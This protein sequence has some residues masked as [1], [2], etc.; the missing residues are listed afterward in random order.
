MQIAVE[1]LLQSIPPEIA[2]NIQLET[3]CDFIDFC[4]T[5]SVNKKIDLAYKNLKRDLINDLLNEVSNIRKVIGKRKLISEI[6]NRP[7][8]S[9]LDCERTLI[10]HELGENN[11]YQFKTNYKKEKLTFLIDN[12]A[13]MNFSRRL[14]IARSLAIILSSFYNLPQ[15]KLMIFSEGVKE[16]DLH[17]IDLKVFLTEYL[18]V[19][20]NGFTDFS[21]AL[22]QFSQHLK[23]N[24]GKGLIIS[25]GVSSV[26]TKLP[27]MTFSR[28][29]VHYIK[30]GNK[31][32]EVDQKL[33]NA[34][35]Q[36][37]GQVLEL[38]SQVSLLKP[39]YQIMK[40]L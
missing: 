34:L 39:L 31:T 38:K 36:S 32:T 24:G 5:N 6:S 18:T 35:Y 26:G 9:V 19:K 21:K 7:D 29:R 8:A 23:L 10:S 15:M 16:V 30:L 37:C 40:R 27:A 11:W 17:K 2:D 28:G 14:D 25:D 20:S 4:E 33:K 1:E 12:S 13:S 3:E 22:V